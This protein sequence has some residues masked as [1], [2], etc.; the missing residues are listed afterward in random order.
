MGVG[1]CDGAPGLAVHNPVAQAVVKP[2]AVKT[3]V[4]GVL[5][6]PAPVELHL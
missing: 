6:G 2:V 1:R 5:Q 3:K 4:A